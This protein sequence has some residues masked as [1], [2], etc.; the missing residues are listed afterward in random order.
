MDCYCGI[1]DIIILW[2]GEWA[3]PEIRWNGLTCDY[4][5]LDDAL[6]DCYAEECGDKSAP[7]DVDRFP[8]WVKENAELVREFLRNMAKASDEISETS[9]A[10][11]K[12]TVK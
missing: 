5:D 7:A 2:H 10:L 12:A 3:D 6:W 1:P 11:D 8:V 9:A 4:Y